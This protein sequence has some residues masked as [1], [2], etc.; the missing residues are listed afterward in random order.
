MHHSVAVDPEGGVMYLYGGVAYALRTGQRRPA[1]VKAGRLYA[2][3]FASSTWEQMDTEGGADGRAGG[4]RPG[5]HPL[6]ATGQLPLQRFL[7]TG[8]APR[9]M[10]N[11]QTQKAPPPLTPGPPQTRAAQR[12]LP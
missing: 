4:K 1:D 7:A 12:R 11:P 5:V 9:C 2:Y 6:A 3:R 8:A 10:S